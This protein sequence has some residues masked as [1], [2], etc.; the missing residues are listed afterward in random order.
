MFDYFSFSF[1][2]IQALGTSE[3]QKRLSD[4][5]ETFRSKKVLLGVDRLDYIKGIPQKLH[6]FESFLENHPEFIGKVSKQDHL[7]EI[8]SLFLESYRN[9]GGSNSS[10]RSI[11]Y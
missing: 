3:V 9:Q 2:S 11:T 1:L 10:G 4:L 7:S 8:S 6:A 5:K